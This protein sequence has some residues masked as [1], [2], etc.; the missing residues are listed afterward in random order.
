MSRPPHIINAPKAL[1]VHVQD[2]YLKMIAEAV[3]SL[4]HNY[5]ALRKDIYAY[6]K[7]NFSEKF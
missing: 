6:I 2:N 4:D 5:G 7:N 1:E 3:G